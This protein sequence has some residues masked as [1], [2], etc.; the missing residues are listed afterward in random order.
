MVTMMSMMMG[1]LAAMMTV[2]LA[3]TKSGLVDGSLSIFRDKVTILVPMLISL[4]ATMI[5]V[6]MT[7]VFEEFKKRSEK[8]AT[9]KKKDI[10]TEVSKHPPQSGA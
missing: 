4:L 6:L 8:D 3:F 2:V 10:S 9:D 5:A 1:I 7:T